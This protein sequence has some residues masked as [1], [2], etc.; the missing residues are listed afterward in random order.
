MDTF[1]KNKKSYLIVDLDNSLLRIDLFKE[2]FFRS[3]LFN[4]VIFFKT[5]SLLFKNKATAKIFISEKIRLDPKTLPYNEDVIK[6]IHKYKKE[7]YKIILATGA[8]V[9]YASKIFNYLNI[10]DEL[11]ATDSKI[12]NIGANK[13][14]SIKNRIGDDFIYLGDSKEDVK[15]WNHCK[16]AILVGKNFSIHNTLKQKNIDILE[17]VHLEKS[18][19]RNLI[20][21]LRVHQWSKNALLFIPAI[22]SHLIFDRLIF[23]QSVTV[24]FAFSCIATSI[25]IFNYVVDVDN[26]RSHPHKKHRPISF[27]G[28]N[29]LEA[30]FLLLTSLLIGV[31]L[32]KSLSFN[33]YI[34]L[35]VYFILNLLYSFFLKK[36]VILDVVFLMSFYVLRL[37]GGHTANAI[38]LSPW[39]LSF[40]IFLFFSLGLLKRYS[41]TILLARVEGVLLEGRGYWVEDRSVLMSLGISSGLVS[42][43][44]LVL[45][46][47]S[48][49]VLKFYKTPIILVSLVPF[50]LLWLSRLW[51][52]AARGK[53]QSDPVLY[54]IKDPYT[55]LTLFSFITIMILA[56]FIAL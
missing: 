47:G 50:F 14:N 54:A 6:I 51:I 53:V 24:F 46:T 19:F 26:D 31:F 29:L 10:F 18:F 42:A 2:I 3:I 56:K 45:Y 27:G 39:L 16:K 38:E 13:L 52:F 4:P 23:S 43:L 28:I 8:P 7:G 40:S 1:H 11:I 9:K 5:L 36:I 34:I 21:Q 49:Q 12:N 35:I 20:R 41:E 33:F 37:I 55:Y 48:E 25:Y 15:I 22:S 30:Y 44:V 17:I 32:A